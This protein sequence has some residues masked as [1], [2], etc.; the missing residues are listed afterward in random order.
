MYKNIKTIGVVGSGIM[1]TGIAQLLASNRMNVLLCDVNIDFV[2]RAKENILRS[3][4]RQVKK[5][6]LQCDEVES[7]L[8]LIRATNKFSDFHEADLVIEAATENEEI[9][10][11]IFKS[12]DLVTDEHSILSSNTSSIAINKLAAVTKRPGK[13]LGIHFMNPAPVISGVEIVK[14]RFTSEETI[15]AANEFIKG[16]GKIPILSKDSP[17]FVIN[18]ILFPMINEAIFALHEGVS[19]KEEIDNGMKLCCNFPIGPL[20]LADMIGLDTVL[21]ILN[22]L[23][24]GFCDKKYYPC[25]LLKELVASGSLGMKSGSGFFNYGE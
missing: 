24:E 19:S 11:D 6:R 7:I 14:G 18:R 23:Y 25:S 4:Q 13:V 3:L 20:K 5:G 1:G 17:G 12:L 9:K 22:T 8:S 10:K 2:K 15:E 21:A 16:I